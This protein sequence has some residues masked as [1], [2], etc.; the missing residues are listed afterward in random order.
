MDGHR[1]ATAA[2]I[3][4]AAKDAREDFGLAVRLRGIVGK[5][6]PQGHADAVM[7]VTGKEQAAAGGVA[8]FALLDLLAERRGP[9]KP[10]GQAKVNP[11]IEASRHGFTQRGNWLG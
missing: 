10:D 6:D 3:V 4:F 7:L 1:A 2:F 5:R 8:C 11:A 9:T